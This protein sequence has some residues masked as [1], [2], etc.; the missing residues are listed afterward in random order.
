M[1]KEI[2]VD[3]KI[4]G[5]FAPKLVELTDNLLFDDV[6]E[7]QELS[8][9]DQSL[10]MVAAMLAM[11]C[12]EQLRFHLD[13]A[14]DNGLKK[15]EL[16]EVITQLAFYSGWSDAMIASNDS[17]GAIFK[18]GYLHLIENACVGG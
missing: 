11:N 3:M 10:V 13:K 12:P 6:W 14:L 7:R 9:R 4:I 18:K 1:S 15:D 5:G 17:E 16:I 8:K 2:S